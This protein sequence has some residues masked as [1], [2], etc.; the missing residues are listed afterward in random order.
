MTTERLRPGVWAVP[1]P[2]LAVN[3]ADQLDPGSEDALGKAVAPPPSVASG[4]WLKNSKFR[5]QSK[6]QK[7]SLCRPGSKRSG[8]SRVPRPI[9]CQNLVFERTG[10]KKTRFTT[11]GISMPM[12]SMWTEIAMRSAFAGSQKSSINDCA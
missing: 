7:T 8:R 9:I 1:S 11:S 4:F 5:H 6:M 3:L 10:L 12:S 2:T